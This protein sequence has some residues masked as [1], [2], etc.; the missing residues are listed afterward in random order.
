MISPRAILSGGVKTPPRTPGFGGEKA[1]G[2]PGILG[3]F[4]KGGDVP[5]TG[6]YQLEKGEHVTPVDEK[7]ESKS[8]RDSEYRKV[9]LKRKTKDKKK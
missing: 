2:G 8:E 6:V 4:E 3:S 7:E 5:K 1:P 9:Y